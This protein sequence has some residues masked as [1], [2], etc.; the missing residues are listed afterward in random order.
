[1]I[2]NLHNINTYVYAYK[3]GNVSFGKTIAQSKYTH[4]KSKK[5]FTRF[6]LT[7]ET[8]SAFDPSF[9]SHKTFSHSAQN[10][11]Y[12]WFC[13]LLITANLLQI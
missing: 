10:I 4:C 12:L 7:A 11:L 9:L 3:V 6:S 5:N 13:V 1:M 8:P 2:K